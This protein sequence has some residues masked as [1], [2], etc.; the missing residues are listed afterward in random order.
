MILQTPLM[1][2]LSFPCIS[3]VADPLRRNFF[4]A[5]RFEQSF[6]VHAGFESRFGTERF[7]FCEFVWLEFFFVIF[8]NRGHIKYRKIP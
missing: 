7:F 1:L 5:D 2:Y 3:A 6:P 4:P 8:G